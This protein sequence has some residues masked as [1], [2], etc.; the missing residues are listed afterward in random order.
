MFNEQTTEFYKGKQL[1]VWKSP[2]YEESRAKAIEIIGKYDCIEEGDFWILMNTIK[3]GETMMYSGLIISHNGCLKINDEQ[4]AENRFMPECVSLDKDGYKNSLV[5]TYC[6]PL[7]GIY[8]VG[9]VS[10]ENCKNSYPYAMAYKRLF[11]RVVLKLCR[12]AYSGV[13][14]DSEA[15]E[16]TQRHEDAQASSTPITE[17][18]IRK[19]NALAEEKG[20][21]IQDICKYFKVGSLDNMTAKDYGKCMAMLNAKKGAKNEGTS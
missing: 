15:D 14:S 2:K 4:T 1:P 16:F 9:E 10:S 12:L 7:Q 11:D 6:N 5:Y 20:S 18:Q 21:N 3:G 13:Y 19:I 17:E 8:E